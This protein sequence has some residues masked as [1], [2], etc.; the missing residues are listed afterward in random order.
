MWQHHI[1][2]NC[3]FKN[4]IKAVSHLYW[5]KYS[6]RFFF[7]FTNYHYIKQRISDVYISFFTPF[8]IM[9]HDIFD[10]KSLETLTEIL[11]STNSF[12]AI[13]LSQFPCLIFSLSPFCLYFPLLF[14]FPCFWDYDKIFLP[15][16]FFC[17]YSM[18]FC[19]IAYTKG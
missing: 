14:W 2:C 10:T 6:R 13:C 3:F 16:I 5:E 19:Y 12:I 17:T 7:F 9:Q 11:N 15:N 8:F 4:S 18:V 1:F